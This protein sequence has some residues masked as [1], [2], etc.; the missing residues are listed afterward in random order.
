[1]K[2]VR[3]SVETAARQAMASGWMNLE[4]QLAVVV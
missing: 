4:P 1:M 2:S 3:A